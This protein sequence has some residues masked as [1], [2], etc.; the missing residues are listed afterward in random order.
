MATTDVYMSE[1]DSDIVT[2]EPQTP[3]TFPRGNKELIYIFKRI[4]NSKNSRRKTG[5]S[6]NM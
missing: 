2:E 4:N 1:A 3:L 6:M 5:I